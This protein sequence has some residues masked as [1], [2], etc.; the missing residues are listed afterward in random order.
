LPRSRRERREVGEEIGIDTDAL[1][2]VGEGP[3]DIEVHPIPANPAKREPRHQHFDL[4]Y[5]FTVAARPDLRLQAD[6]VSD[7]AWLPANAIEPAAL[8]ERVAA[9]TLG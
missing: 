7:F 9:T 2:A 4:R 3:I 5:A 6:E 1:V 8:A